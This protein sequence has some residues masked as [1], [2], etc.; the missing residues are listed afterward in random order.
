MILKV[1][2]CEFDVVKCAVMTHLGRNVNQLVL[3]ALSGL[4]G[5]EVIVNI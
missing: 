5:A 1:T 4:D 2:C 3:V